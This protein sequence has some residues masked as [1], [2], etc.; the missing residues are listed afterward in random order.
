MA[1]QLATTAFSLLPSKSLTWHTGTRSSNKLRSALTFIRLGYTKSSTST[2]KR[3]ID[4]G[5]LSRRLTSRQETNSTLEDA[6]DSYGV[7]A[8]TGEVTDCDELCQLRT[9]VIDGHEEQVRR[10]EF[11]AITFE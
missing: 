1:L 6:D 9:A 4:H 5:S 2:V 3:S 10:G 7:P 11:Q 8:Y